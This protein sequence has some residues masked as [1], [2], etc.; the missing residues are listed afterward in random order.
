MKL[1]TKSQA[2]YA[3]MLGQLVSTIGSSM[4]RFG[5]GI[6]VLQETG[7]KAVYSV[8]LFFAVLPLGLGSLFAGPLVDR[9][10]R[11][12]V[13][14][15]GNIAASFSTLII[16][17]LFFSG[18][19]EF[20]HLY[21]ALAV[22]GVANAFVFPALDASVPLLVDQE[23]LGR[24][25]GL[26]QMIQ[27][28]ETILGPALAGLVLGSFSLGTIFVVDFVT[29]GASIFAL[30]LSLIPQPEAPAEKEEET[31]WQS[32]AFGVTYIRERPAFLY[33]M[34][35]VTLTMLL[36][37]GFGYA[38]V[39]PLVL[40]FASEQAAGFVLSGFG[41][42]AMIGGILLTVWGGPS[43]RMDGILGAMVLASGAAVL[44]SLRENVWLTA[45]AMVLIGVSFVFMIGLNRVI[46]QVKAEP[47]VLGRV[48]SL[49]VF[50]GVGAQSLGVLL[51]GI[52]AEHWFEPLFQEGGALAGSVGQLIGVGDGRGMAF[53][54][55]VA[56]ILLLALTA[57][58]FALPPIR[59]L[60][61]QIPD[62]KPPVTAV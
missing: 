12:M 7:D 14:I 27:A 15:V 55:I 39:T 31:L 21:I 25:A 32:F 62:Y 26:T 57:V 18:L 5:L 54:F 20:W 41:V 10:N 46:W 42:G 30:A 59:L 52:L 51:A 48:F 47:S 28:F 56:G 58:S 19:L 33:L 34:G 36:M 23:Q 8:L 61:D 38:L 11:R 13:L 9:W 2:F 4:T 50:F 60:E 22:N 16:A 6:W 45:V 37:P 49:R 44:V 29:F 1:L 24:A 35:F 17:V 3:I 40:S 53:M 43:R